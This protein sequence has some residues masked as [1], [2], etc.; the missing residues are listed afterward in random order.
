MPR[1][2]RPEGHPAPSM[3]EKGAA[4][5]VANN[6]DVAG[7]APAAASRT[8]ARIVRRVE[9]RME[10]DHRIRENL[11]SFLRVMIRIH[12]KL[13]DDQYLPSILKLIGSMPDPREFTRVEG[14]QEQLLMAA[15]RQSPM[16][17][18]K[19]IEAGARLDLLSRGMQEQ[20]LLPK[21]LPVRWCNGD[22][23]R[24]EGEETLLKL[25]FVG[26]L[27]AAGKVEEPALAVVLASPG[28]DGMVRYKC[29]EKGKD[30]GDRHKAKGLGLVHAI[31]FERFAGL[32]GA[33]EWAKALRRRVEEGASA[34]PVEAGAREAW[35]EY[36][37][38]A[39]PAWR[40][41]EAIRSGDEIRRET[42]AEYNPGAFS[43]PVEGGPGS[44]PCASYTPLDVAIHMKRSKLVQWM[45]ELGARPD[46]GYLNV[47]VRCDV[48]GGLN[49]ELLK[50][51]FEAGNWYPCSQ[52]NWALF[53][54]TPG[55]E[56]CLTV[57]VSRGVAPEEFMDKARMA[58][59]DSWA[60]KADL[61]RYD[62]RRALT[63]A[64]LLRMWR[65][66]DYLWG[67]GGRWHSEGHKWLL[68]EALSRHPEVALEFLEQGW[69]VTCDRQSIVGRLVVALPGVLHP[70]LVKFI[71]ERWGDVFGGGL[72]GALTRAHLDT[73]LDKFYREVDYSFD[74]PS[75]R[76]Q[77]N[78]F[79]VKCWL[80]SVLTLSRIPGFS[81]W[82][83][84]DDKTV[85]IQEL[86]SH[87]IGESQ[88][89]AIMGEVR[90]TAERSAWVSATVRGGLQEALRA[91]AATP[92]EEPASAEESVLVPK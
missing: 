18:L 55:A 17:G 62:I 80:R 42:L 72:D 79:Q 21:T 2:T 10:E 50:A 54:D 56:A 81:E 66:A 25:D 68:N 20:L 8:P 23:A 41:M 14:R 70:R 86:I 27:L 35:V 36:Q 67:P 24:V 4:R 51:L 49:G 16:V 43:F 60:R 84:F 31:T 39:K 28:Y 90:W 75:I 26:R 59:C 77:L 85:S 74:A 44:V 63:G 15:L 45:I 19:M 13:Q 61:G 46:P 52:Y 5:T 30:A 58:T 33:E 7:L 40:L 82:V 47:L 34:R 83:R 9:T 6:P 12:S 32:M 57:V 37:D 29:G 89:E 71:T 48:E 22:L 64:D 78:Q 1:L 38:V 65:R 73:R 53:D 3:T 91:T 88:A 11:R 69:E 92:A 76:D 87:S